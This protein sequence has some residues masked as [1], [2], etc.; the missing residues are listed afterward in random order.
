MSAQAKLVLK[1]QIF[2]PPGEVF[3][4]WTQPDVMRKWLAPGENVVIEASTDVRLG[5]RFRI[6][7]TAPDGSL[8]TIEGSYKE[9]IPGRRIVMTW[10]YSGPIELLRE[11]ETLLEV[12]LS[13]AGPD[14]TTMTVTQTR[15]ATAEAAECY[16]E[17]WPTCFGKLEQLLKAEKPQ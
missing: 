8:H 2:G 9:L 16:G 14:A 12:E 17:G 6:H 13:A 7:S 10:G 15:I 4:A 3:Q 5:G 11:M 1:R